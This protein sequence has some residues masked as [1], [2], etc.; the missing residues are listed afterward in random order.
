MN[1]KCSINI[2]F[3]SFLTKHIWDETPEKGTGVIWIHPGFSLCGI[4]LVQKGMHRQ[5]CDSSIFFS[6]PSSCRPDLFNIL[7]IKY[8]QRTQRRVKEKPQ[9]EKGQKSLVFLIVPYE[10]NL[11]LAHSLSGSPHSCM[12]NDPQDACHLELSMIHSHSQSPSQ[13]LF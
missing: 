2:S 10:V 9:L 1:N 13:A 6:F 7:P 4:S 5:S 3:P 12:W 8:F 11:V